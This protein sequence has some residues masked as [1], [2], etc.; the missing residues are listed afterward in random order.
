MAN[1][2]RCFVKSIYLGGILSI[3]SFV[4]PASIF[5]ETSDYYEINNMLLRSENVLYVHNRITNMYMDKT[6]LLIHFRYHGIDEI[7]IL[8]DGKVKEVK[9]LFQIIY[10]L[11]Y[12][13]SYIQISW[14][15]RTNQVCQKVIIYFCKRLILAHCME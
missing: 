3:F 10:P 11:I 9:L 13:M 14:R 6:N 4:G 12:F 7:D 1:A 5:A 8:P 15:Q 2:R